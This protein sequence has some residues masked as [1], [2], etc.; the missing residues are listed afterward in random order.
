MAHT[1]V[2]KSEDITVDGRKLTLSPL[3][4]LEIQQIQ[5]KE[6]ALSK[7]E[8]RWLEYVDF[9]APIIQAHSVVSDPSAGELILNMQSWAFVWRRLLVLSDMISEQAGEAKPE[10]EAA[11]TGQ[12]STA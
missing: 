5:Q 4:L 8:I 11:P 9:S 3:T 2:T 1:F 12:A 6:I 7:K 10:T